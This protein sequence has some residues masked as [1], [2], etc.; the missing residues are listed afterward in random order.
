MSEITIMREL[1]SVLKAGAHIAQIYAPRWPG[2]TP[3]ERF[4]V[5]QGEQRRAVTQRLVVRAIHA[6]RLQP[7]DEPCD[8]FAPRIW[9]LKPPPNKG[10]A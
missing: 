5:Q 3:H 10:N 9:R 8:G 1:M 2:D 6:H 4:V 7:D